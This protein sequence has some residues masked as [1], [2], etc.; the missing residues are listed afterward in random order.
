MKGVRGSALRP[1]VHPRNRRP[2][3]GGRVKTGGHVSHIGRTP[4][5]R[6]TTLAFLL[7]CAGAC[8][9]HGGAKQDPVPAAAPDGA[10][11]ARRPVADRSPGREA[12]ASEMQDQSVT[13]VEELLVGRFPGVQVMNTPGGLVVRVRGQSSILGNSEP[14]FVVDGIPITPGTGGALAINPRDVARIE[15]LK[16]AAETAIYGPRGANGVIVITTKR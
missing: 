14:L 9:H 2:P 11:A 8:S 1:S 3:M 15:V 10:R 12:T 13:R 16:D 6:T 4:G 5:A 7:A